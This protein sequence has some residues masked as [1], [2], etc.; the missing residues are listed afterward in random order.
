MADITVDAPSTPADSAVPPLATHGLTTAEVLQRKSQGLINDVPVKSSRPLSAILRTNFLSLTNVILFGIMFVLVLVGEPGDAF[1]TGGVVMLNV[2]VGVFQEV[3][4]KRQL[5]QIALLTRP[6]V[7]AIRG[8]EQR[9]I[10]PSEIVVGDALVIEPGDQIVVDGRLLTDKRID[11]DESLLTGESD[12]VPKEQGDELLSGSFCVSGSGVFEAEK[13]GT[14]SFAYQLTA[15]AREYRLVMTPLQSQVSLLVRLLVILA[16]SLAVMLFMS[17][18]IEQEPFSEIVEDTAVVISLVPQGLLLMITVAYALGAVRIAQK[19]ALVQQINAVESLSNVDILCLD[20]TGTLTTNRIEMRQA[21]PIGEDMTE[22][23]LRELAGNFVASTGRVNRT[24]EA[25]AEAC[26]ACDEYPTSIEIPFSSA[27]KWSGA[28]FPGEGPMLGSYVLGA[29]EMMLHRIKGGELLERHIETWTD[30]GLR[31]LLLAYHP[32]P[33]QPMPESGGPELPQNLQPLGWLTFSDEIRGDAK[34]VLEQF[35]QA[36]VQFKLISGDNPQTVA[37]LAQLAGISKDVHVISGLQLAELSEAQY[38]TAV[39]QTTVFGRITP[40]Q[41]Q[42]IVK[43]LRAKGHYVAMMGDGVN[44]VLSLKGAQMGIA[45]E[46][47]SQA[48]RAVADMVLLDD[49]FSVLPEAIKEGQRILNGMQDNMRL[50]LARTLYAALLIIIAGYIGTEFPFT[51]KHNA[52][53]TTLPVGIP[54]FFLTVWARPGQ[55]KKDLLRSVVE[56]TLPAGFSITIVTL[57]VYL[58]YINDSLAL[59]R[60]TLTTTALLCGLLLILFAE[61]SIERWESGERLRY[62]RR[63]IWLALAMLGLYVLIFPFPGARDFFELNTLAWMDL[64]V[65]VVAVIIWAAI[66]INLWRYDVFARLLNPA[67]PEE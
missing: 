60:T 17:S 36:G 3:R 20:K 24:A 15:G 10:D 45:M 50:F 8:G 65:V 9:E 39:E 27:H 16:I 14:D 40:E 29:P 28:T 56:F 2:T 59:Q 43:A 41:K 25:I 49:Q 64:A 18:T 54:A 7:T 47:G 53:L 30:L 38:A 61:H 58:M 11:V 12:H 35:R 52:I 44:D 31:V 6:Q 51:P 55:P 23:R 37:A 13:V 21:I 19:G 42:A 46:S 22:D 1:V 33:L 57:V 5:D 62:D 34:Q 26:L 63:R 4:A 48:T 32:D 67:P 66:V